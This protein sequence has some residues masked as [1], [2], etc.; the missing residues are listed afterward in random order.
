M[1]VKFSTTELI[2]HSNTPG[3]NGIMWLSSEHQWQVHRHPLETH[4]NYVLDEQ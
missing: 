3:E 1:L 4:Y 2:I